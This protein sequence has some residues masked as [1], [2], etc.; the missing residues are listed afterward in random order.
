MS[1]LID[2]LEEHGISEEDFNNGICRVRSNL[3]EFYNGD[4]V[5]LAK[6]NPF[7]PAIFT[8]A[9]SAP[10][11]T[12]DVSVSSALGSFG[13][14]TAST[15]LFNIKHPSKEK[16]RLQH[17]CMEGPENGVYVRGKSQETYVKFPVYWKDLVDPHTISVHVTPIGSIQQIFVDGITSAGFSAHRNDNYV[18][19]HFFYVAYASRKD[20]PKLDVEIPE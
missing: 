20:V 14:M 18:S 1:T 11:A 3:I 13:T 2:I 9:V 19:P 7:G 6:F 15:K 5:L 17:A 10:S 8:T 4:G 12:F 16:M